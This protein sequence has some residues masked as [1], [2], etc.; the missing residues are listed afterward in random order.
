MVPTVDEYEIEEVL[1]VLYDTC[2]MS[3]IREIL[4]I[5]AKK[6]PPEYLDWLRNT[7]KKY[8]GPPI[9]LVLQPGKGL[10]DAMYHGSM[11]ASG[12]HVQ[13]LASDTENDPADVGKMAKLAYEH[14]DHIITTS[15]RLNKELLSDYPA[16]KK[17]FNV[18]FN[19]G[20]RVLFATKETDITYLYQCTPVKYI[21]AHKY[22]EDKTAFIMET[23]L[24]TSI[25]KYPYIE[26]PSRVGKRKSGESSSDLKYYFHFLTRALKIFWDVRICGKD[27]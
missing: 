19:T 5:Y 9:S 18:L 22:P 26:I 23:A 25:K 4:I 11:I 13:I 1:D 24:L 7:I 8:N 27:F 12:S 10:G 14:P 15:R 6:T 17:P 21:R 2:D 3:L 20:L 16:Y